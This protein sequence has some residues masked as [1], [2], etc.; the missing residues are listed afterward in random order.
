MA[1]MVAADITL[2]Q[3]ADL[4]KSVKVAN[5]GF[6]FLTMSNGNVL[7]VNPAGEKA[8]GLS[9]NKD[10]SSQGVTGLSRNL[11]KS[12]QTA[13]A[14]LELPSDGSTEIERLVL[15]EA[16]RTGPISSRCIA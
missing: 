1:G 2:E 15:K 8:L 9:I 11:S 14:S 10:A 13:I 12:T 16:T 7:A 6:G 4:V 5:T 3:L